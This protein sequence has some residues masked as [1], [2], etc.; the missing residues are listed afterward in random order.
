MAR[1]LRPPRAARRV[2]RRGGRAPR[3]W[4]KAR[5]DPCGGTG[6]PIAPGRAGSAASASG[7]IQVKARYKLSVT[8]GEAV[9]M[10]AL[11]A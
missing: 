7:Q 9:A 4:S 10:R 3:G 11:L 6:R 2:A 5:P 8:A 1:E